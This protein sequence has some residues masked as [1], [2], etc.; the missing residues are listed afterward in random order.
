MNVLC[1]VGGCRDGDE[2]NKVLLARHRD[3]KSKGRRRIRDSD[4]SVQV[5]ERVR[6]LARGSPSRRQRHNSF[7]NR[8]LC[9]SPSPLSLQAMSGVSRF[10]SHNTVHFV[11]GMS[12]ARQRVLQRLR[13]TKQ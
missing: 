3:E 7:F 6:E 8:H 11:D 13:K 10:R 5:I 1:G 12:V 9:S 4:M 2:T